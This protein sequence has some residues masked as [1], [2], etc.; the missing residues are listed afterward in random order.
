MK[1]DEICERIQGKYLDVARDWAE[2]LGCDACPGAK[3][4]LLP[5]SS[6]HLSK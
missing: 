3:R 5:N 4:V 2:L 6:V 1:E